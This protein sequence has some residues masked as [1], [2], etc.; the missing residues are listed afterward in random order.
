MP[1][2]RPAAVYEVVAAPLPEMSVQSGFQVFPPSVLR[3]CWYLVILES[4]GPAQRTTI[5][6]LPARAQTSRG[7]AGGGSGVAVVRA[8]GPAVTAP[9]TART[10]KVYLEPLVS[11]VTACSVVEAELPEISVQSGDHGPLPTR[12]RYRYLLIAVS[13][14][15]SQLRVTFPFPGSALRPPGAGGGSGLGV[16]VTRAPA[17]G[18]FGLRTARTSKVYSVSLVRPVTACWM[19]DAELFAMSVQSGFQVVPPSALRRCWYLLIVASPGLFQLSVVRA[20]PATAP[21]P[22]GAGGLLSTRWFES[23]ATP[24]W[25]SLA[26]SPVAT[27]SIVPPFRASVFVTTATPSVDLFGETTVYRNTSELVPWPAA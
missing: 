21:R 17:P 13:P 26:S 18:L 7:A 8:A 1:L 27:D 15:S 2:V 23:C 5:C 16:A 10:S 4:P 19:V 22:V 9:R 3:R 12:A 14:G 24:V 25:P 20:L 11:P 6:A